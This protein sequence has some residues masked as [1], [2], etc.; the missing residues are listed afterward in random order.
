MRFFFAILFY[1]LILNAATFEKANQL[2]KQKKYKEAFKLYQKSNSIIAQN[3]IAMMYYY[4]YG[5]GPD[6]AKAVGIL[7]NLLKQKITK[8]EKSIILYNLGMMYYNG[9]ISNINHKLLIDR[10][11]A[12][13]LIK[14]SA[15]LDYKPAK[16]FYD[17]IYNN[18]D[19]N[20]TK[21]K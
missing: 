10:K 15:D 8:K 11:K 18:K 2:Y 19:L 9:Y 12:K 20:A 14:K 16:I 4:G 3:N 5:V 17:K 13:E 21:T 6:Q 7:K 1:T